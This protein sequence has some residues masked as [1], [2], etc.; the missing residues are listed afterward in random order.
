M[1]Q[2]ALAYFTSTSIRHLPRLKLYNVVVYFV[3]NEEDVG[4]V[5]GSSIVPNDG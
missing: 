2:L 4:R 3:E 1:I 5:F